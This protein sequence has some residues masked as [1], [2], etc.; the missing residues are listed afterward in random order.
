M[1]A[2]CGRITCVIFI[3]RKNG[4]FIFNDR[5]YGIFSSAFRQIIAMNAIAEITM[6]GNSTVGASSSISII[7][8]VLLTVVTYLFST[9]IFVAC[10]VQMS[11]TRKIS[12]ST[13]NENSFME[14]VLMA[15]P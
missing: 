8:A 11:R 12:V 10:T 5:S 4:G 6:T 1:T 7:A 14:I 13:Y 2:A 15:T 3:T 9:V